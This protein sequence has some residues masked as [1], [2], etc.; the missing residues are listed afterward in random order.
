MELVSV[1]EEEVQIEGIAWHRRRAIKKWSYA[2]F[3]CTC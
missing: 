2:I 3:L 1:A